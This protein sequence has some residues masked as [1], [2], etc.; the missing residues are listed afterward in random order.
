[1]VAMPPKTKIYY[2]KTCPLD[3]DCCSKGSWKK[4]TRGETEEKV[5][6]GVK[7]HLWNKHSMAGSVMESYVQNIDLDFYW[8]YNVEPASAPSAPS[9]SKVASVPPKSK[10]TG[11]KPAPAKATGAKPAPKVLE[12]IKKG[13]VVKKEAPAGVK[14]EKRSSKEESDDAQDLDH[15]PHIQA[16]EEAKEAAT[17]ARDAILKLKEIAESAAIAYELEALT[18]QASIDQ[19]D[20]CLAK[21]WEKI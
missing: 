21:A 7:A 6:S 1:M 19:L 10:A 12:M 15:N 13:W 20:I 16:M 4:T 11:C 17:N 9:A 2:A 18:L 3:P 5:K 8:D 14:T